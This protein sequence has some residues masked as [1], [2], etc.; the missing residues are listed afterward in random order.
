MQGRLNDRNVK[1]PTKPD[2]IHKEVRARYKE[3]QLE[4]NGYED[5]VRRL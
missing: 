4:T 1:V 2:K 3:K 5:R